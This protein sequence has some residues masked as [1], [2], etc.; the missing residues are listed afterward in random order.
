M[1]VLMNLLV[2]AD[3]SLWMDLA[4]YH[5]FQKI[6]HLFQSNSLCP[7]HSETRN[8]TKMDETAHPGK[9]SF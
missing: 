5:L 9:G 4:S 3:S 7:S 1:N 8:Q 2:L 6:Q